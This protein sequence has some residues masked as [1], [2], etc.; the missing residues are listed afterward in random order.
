MRI[1]IIFLVTFM[2]PQPIFVVPAILPS[3]TD[4]TAPFFRGIRPFRNYGLF[5]EMMTQ[6]DRIG[7]KE[8]IRWMNI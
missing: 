1:Q 8:L 6:S 7:K 5:D 3:G 4:I 2:N